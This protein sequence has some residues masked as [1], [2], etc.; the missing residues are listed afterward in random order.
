MK[1][2]ILLFACFTLAFSVNLSAQNVAGSVE[3]GVYSAFQRGDL[4]GA[5]EIGDNN[6]MRPYPSFEGF[7]YSIPTF[8]GIIEYHFGTVFALIGVLRYENTP[9]SLSISGERNYY[10]ATDGSNRTF[11]SEFTCSVD[12]KAI[13]TSLLGKTTISGTNLSILT[14]ADISIVA[15]NSQEIRFYLYPEQGYPITIDS[16]PNLVPDN[17]YGQPHRY[18]D[19]TH[20]SITMYK[21]EIDNSSRS[22]LFGITLG[23]QYDIPVYTISE[24]EKKFVTLTPT[25]MARRAISDISTTNYLRIHSF[26]LGFALKVGL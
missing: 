21:G 25:F 2:I 7:G 5:L 11:D 23:L 8:G 13:T 12:V 4:S 20:T 15:S 26:N 16:L 14:G 18:L 6:G 22:L 1:H 17:I 9:Q 24:S 3:V 10:K 19:D